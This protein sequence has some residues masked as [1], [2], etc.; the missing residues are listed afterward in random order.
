MR[1]PFKILA[2]MPR[3]IRDTLFLLALIGWIVLMQAP[4]IPLLVTAMCVVLLLWRGQLTIKQKHLPSRWVRAGLVLCALAVT[5]SQFRTILGRDAGSVFILLMLVLKTLELKARRDIFVIFFLGFFTLLSHFFYS[6]NLLTAIGILIG[7]LGL[8]TGLVNAHTP[9]GYPPLR[10]SF[11]LALRMALLGAP[12][13]V[14]LFMFFPRFA[15]L[16]GLPAQDSAK[17]GLSNDMQ[18][19]SIAELALDESTAFRVRF[20][21]TPPP[22]SAMYFR[23][24]VLAQLNGTQW[25]AAE[26]LSELDT[27]MARGTNEKPTNPMTA[28]AGDVAIEY[29]ILLQPHQMRWLLTL[30][31][32]IQAPQLPA[33]WRT[34]QLST[35]EW[36][37]HRPIV[38]VLRYQASSYLGAQN[39]RKTLDAKTRRRYTQLPEGTDPRTKTLAQ[40]MLSAH[41]QLNAQ[42]RPARLVQAALTRLNTG[43]YV[44]T[45]TPGVVQNHAADVF[46]FDSKQG[47]C[48][49]ISNA[50]VV[51]MRHMRIPARIV[52]GY[53]GGELNPL[54]SMWTVRQ[55]DAHAWAEV[56]LP[57]QGWVRVDPTSAVSVERIQNAQRLQNTGA[58]G[59]AI[60]GISPE[61]ANMLQ[62]SM[63]Q[64]R[65]IWDVANTRWNSWVLN[66]T[67]DRQFNL[68][69][70]LGF[71]NISWM[72]LVQILFGILGVMLALIGVWLWYTRRTVDAWLR[73]FNQACKKLEKMGANLP[74]HPALTPR[75]LLR[76]LQ[77]HPRISRIQHTKSS[78]KAWRS[79]LLKMEAQRYATTQSKP[80]QLQILKKQLANLP[81]LPF[82]R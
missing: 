72:T 28:T 38:D 44:Y 21:G 74:T 37:S 27:R 70:N 9:A 75:Q 23:G 57:N 43:G 13:M 35:L 52:T 26:P 56:W 54:D 18:V 17:T 64:L 14:A 25:K 42:Q 15:P 20:E 7:V 79:W 81:K 68:L 71:S 58:V 73:L 29:E 65:N 6:Q 3:E 41:A 36:V 63:I 24:P 11:W 61:V 19:G 77:K 10:Q 22:Q 66:Y 1:N 47:F 49:H 69:R 76:W 31:H 30:E 33:G 32:A 5:I 62:R 46:W 34:G 51:L 12:I 80:T 67:Q 48:E 60:E 53:Q 8:L 82:R 2:A 16:W 39:T 55:S 78:I 4:H 40:E 45:L 50:F 59:T